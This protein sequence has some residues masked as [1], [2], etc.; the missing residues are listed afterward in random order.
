MIK[1][2]FIA[3][4]LLCCD[5]FAADWQLFDK[6]AGMRSYIDRSSQGNKMTTRIA[7][8]KSVY[9]KPQQLRQKSRQSTYVQKMELVHMD[10]PARSYLIQ[11]TIYSSKDGELAGSK[12]GAT[13]FKPVFPDSVSEVRYKTICGAHYSKLDELHDQG[14]RYRDISDPKSKSRWNPFAK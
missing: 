11:E 4:A 5:A 3:L 10:C 7:W 1:A 13:G 6:S 2:L 9:E 8:V 12:Q 14:I